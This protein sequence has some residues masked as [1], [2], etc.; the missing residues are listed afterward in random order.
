MENNT[1][2]K[3]KKLKY[4]IDEYN[5]F[6]CF[7]AAESHSDIPFSPSRL[8]FAATRSLFLEN[9]RKSKN[10]FLETVVNCLTFDDF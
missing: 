6:L 8:D 3:K 4:T 10:Y 2:L 7:L 1:A 9:N 5:R